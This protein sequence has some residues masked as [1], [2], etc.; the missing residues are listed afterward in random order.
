MPLGEFADRRRFRRPEPGA[1]P[2]PPARGPEFWAETVKGV[3]KEVLEQAGGNMATTLHNLPLNLEAGPTDPGGNPGTGIDPVTQPVP[4]SDRQA[5]TAGSAALLQ[6]DAA[7]TELRL[8]PAKRAAN[9]KKMA[10]QMKIAHGASPTRQVGIHEN[11]WFKSGGEYFRKGERAFPGL[12]NG[13]ERFA[14]NGNAAIIQNIA[15]FH[16]SNTVVATATRTCKRAQPSVRSTKARGRGTAAAAGPQVTFKVD[17]TEDRLHH[18][19]VRHTY[20][21]FDF[22]LIKAVNNF[23]PG[24]DF[25]YAD[26]LAL[27][28]DLANAIADHLRDQIL[29]ELANFTDAEDVESQSITGH[30][31]KANQHQIFY[32]ANLDYADHQGQA[33]KWDVELDTIAPDGRS[34]DTY[35]VEELNQI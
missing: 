17:I 32:I 25:D 18:S 3:P 34:A 16:G 13:Q 23:W 33:F 26:V 7:Y 10:D 35:T 24:K 14:D 4:G 12:V 9:W 1:E 21:H 20:R 8:D 30:N 2:A 19:C 5:H 27:A 6:V 22:N 28:P 31:V 15:G 11:M 29:D